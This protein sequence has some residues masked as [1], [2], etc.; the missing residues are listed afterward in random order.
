MRH[1]ELV[2]RLDA[3]LERAVEEVLGEE[4]R[5]LEGIEGHQRE[6]KVAVR[7]VEMAIAQIGEEV[8]RSGGSG[9]REKARFV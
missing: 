4:R 8:G 1:H 2:L 6:I 5:R 7:D 9:S 3:V